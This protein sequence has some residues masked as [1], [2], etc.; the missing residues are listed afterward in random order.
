M[1]RLPAVALLLCLSAFGADQVAL[2]N[3]DLISGSIIQKDATKLVL[4][5]E[6]FGELTIPW[7]KVKSLHGDSAE[8]V[9]L[10]ASDTPKQKVQ[11]GG[12]ELLIVTT[13]GAKP[14]QNIQVAVLRGAEQKRKYD[15]Q[16]HP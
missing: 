4:K 2:T 1:Y 16:E 14:A 13:G 5:T 6:M 10:F 3:G 9:H 15:R 7:T 12:D 11:T 8:L